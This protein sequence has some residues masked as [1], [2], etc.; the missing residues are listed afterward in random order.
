MS[1]FLDIQMTPEGIRRAAAGER[2]AQRELYE[3]LAGPMFGLVRR[4]VRNRATAEDLFQDSMESV[5][6]H[7]P[8]YRGEAPLGAWVRQLTLRH[9]LMHLRSPWQRARG[10]LREILPGL[11][12]LGGFAAGGAGGSGARTGHFVGYHAHGAVVARRG[13]VDPR[14]DRCRLRAYHEF[15]KIAVGASAPDA[16]RAA[17]GSRGGCMPDRVTPYDF[18][19]FQRRSVRAAAGRRS[20][21]FSAVASVAV[22]GLV[23]TLAVVTQHS[24]LEQL[25][26][27][28][29][30]ACHG[31]RASRRCCR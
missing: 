13:R 11:H 5:L 7:L 2:D 22:L 14:R 4:V 31:W 9:C 6:R 27:F 30:G 24:G 8:Q 18:D 23:V 25:C 26:S 10:A 12:A 19:E 20:W 21:A 29:S 1:R 15:F 16:A 28:S 17:S 3:Q